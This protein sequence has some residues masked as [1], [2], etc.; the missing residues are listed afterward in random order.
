[1]GTDSRTALL[2]TDR[3]VDERYFPGFRWR[4]HSLRTWLQDAG[5]DVTH[6]PLTAATIP[7]V[8]ERLIATMSSAGALARQA[9]GF[10]LVVVHGIAVPHTVWLAQRLSR[11]HD[12]VVLDAC[13]SFVLWAGAYTWRTHPFSRLKVWL[14]RVLLRSSRPLRCSYV[15]AR[16]AVTDERAGLTG[17]SVVI[18]NSVPSELGNLASYSGP[19]T[20]IVVPT[21][22]YCPHNAEAFGWFEDAVRKGELTLRVPVEVYGPGEP[23]HNLPPGVTYN[24][25]SPELRTI[26]EGQTAVFAP[27]V[28]A[29]GLQGKY[30]ESV[31]AG[32]PVAIGRQPSEALAPYAG[33]LTYDSRAEL[34][35]ALNA[36]QDF[37]TPLKAGSSAAAPESVLQRGRRVI[38][39]VVARRRGELIR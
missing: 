3:A 17:D 21:D 27:N 15:T 1:M 39:E 23:D 24:G 9:K 38:D 20:R 14:A 36:L 4:V 10:D 30:L 34:V 7:S 16:D 6:R 12:A 19:P 28:R 22:F 8:S 25:W 33:A 18:P 5:F 32:R 26:Y 31:A 13:D 11:K 35:A 37:E 2:I 29:S